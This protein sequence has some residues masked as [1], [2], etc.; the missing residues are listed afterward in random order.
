MKRNLCLLLLFGL[1]TMAAV[2]APDAAKVA[3][4]ERTLTFGMVMYADPKIQTR[5]LQPFVDFLSA[6]TG[7][8]VV[9]KLFH[10]YYTVLN[11][12]DH[13][14]LDMAMLAPIIYALCMDQDGLEYLGTAL[15]KGM[16][17]YH[18]ILMGRKDSKIF[19]IQDLKGKKIGFVDK[20][21][22]SGFVYP[23]ITLREQGLY[24]ETR[25]LYTPVFFGNHEQAIRALLEG[26]VDV[27]A[28]FEN[29]FLY[30]KNQIGDKHDL[31]INDF[32]IVKL[33]PDRIPNDA[34]VCRRE[35]GKQTIDKLRLALKDFGDEIKKND[36]PFKGSYVSGFRPDLKKAYVDV[37]NFLG[38]L[39]QF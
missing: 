20:H 32:R 31:S 27:T 18:A 12:V 39:G 29:I 15:E 5:S 37:K 30:T 4:P 33:I 13:E 2:S 9:L 16:P 21:S 1:V 19:S 38:K 34:F 17:F 25:P 6:R 24:D 10:D 36:S 26:R 23:A 14:N 7:E 28:S 11:E 35:L 3:A 8:K 22:A